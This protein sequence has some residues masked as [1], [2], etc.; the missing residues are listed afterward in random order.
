VINSC[1]SELGSIEL[2]EF[3]IVIESESESEG[4]REMS[5]VGKNVVNAD[6]EGLFKLVR[7]RLFSRIHLVRICGLEVVSAITVINGFT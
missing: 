2:A 1:R 3:A 4:R 5:Q 7:F 6:S